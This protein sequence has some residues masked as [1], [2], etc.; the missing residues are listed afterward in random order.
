[1]NPADHSHRQ[2]CL[3]RNRKARYVVLGITAYLLFVPLISKDKLPTQ[4]SFS[5]MFAKALPHVP[6]AVFWILWV[7]IFIFYLRA[8]V[9][10]VSACEN[11]DEKIAYG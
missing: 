6:I 2:F 8:L 9:A 1:M 3:V 5:E 7:G 10:F 11:L 4:I